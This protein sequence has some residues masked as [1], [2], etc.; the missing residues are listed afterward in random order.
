AVSENQVAISDSL[1]NRIVITNHDGEIMHIYGTGEPGARDGG[2]DSA[3]FFAPQGLTFASN[4]LYV[5]DTGN[6]LIRFIDFTHN[7]VRTVAGN[8]QVELARRGEFEAL[9]TGLRS[10]WDLA[11]RAPW[12]YIA[13]A[14]N[15]QIWRLN[16]TTGKLSP[17]AGSGR[18][19]IDDGSLRKAE[20]SQPSGLSLFADSLYV[21]DAEDSAI[22]RIDLKKERVETLVGT[23][24]FDFGDRDGSFKRTQL[25]HVTGVA[26][27]DSNTVL[28]ADTYNHKLKK[29]DLEA[30][31]TDT[32]AGSGKPARGTE[33]TPELNEPGGIA[34]LGRRVLITD[35]NNHRI[36]VY[37]TDTGLLKEWKIQGGEVSKTKQGN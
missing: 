21:A 15:H 7:S 16:I 20:F 23:G 36:L 26:V 34:V 25:Q 6:H 9:K 11:L 5:A 35:T 19:G 22:R 18:E 8:G 2:I 12:L 4:G 37:D 33:I 13:M 3:Q 27:L 10:P 29:L 17:Y 14:G 1:H 32:L 28:I 31:V 24:L 30:R